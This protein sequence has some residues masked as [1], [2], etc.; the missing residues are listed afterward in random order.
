VL[1]WA[2]EEA[3]LTVVDVETT[4]LEPERGHRIC[5]IGA[6]K[7]RSGQEIDRFHTMVNPERPMPPETTVMNGITPDMLSGAPPAG[8]V[9]PAFCTFIDRTVLAAYNARFDLSFL[10]ME[11]ARAGLP[12]LRLPVID[13]LWLARQLLPGLPRYP[14]GNVARFLG[15][16][17]RQAHRALGDV[18]VTV[19]ILMQF[20]PRLKQQGIVTVG[21][22]VMEQ[23]RRGV[24]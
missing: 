21:D 7:Y 2:L 13:V 22:L 5:E 15:I 14:L 10:R 23:T 18:E 3:A 17:H 1:S 11:L 9:L 12:A 8:S 24:L 19:R 4:G 20:I 6:V 16:P